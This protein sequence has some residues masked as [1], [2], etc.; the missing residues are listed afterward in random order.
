MKADKCYCYSE[1]VFTPYLSGIIKNE[2]IYI[3]VSFMDD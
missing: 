1:N 2:L 3:P